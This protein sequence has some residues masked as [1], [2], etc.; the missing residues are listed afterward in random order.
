[1]FWIYLIKLS[2]VSHGG[3][4]N[5]PGKGLKWAATRI[6]TL[7][8]Q[9][10]EQQ[11]GDEDANRENLQY[12][13]HSLK[14]ILGH[15][16]NLWRQHFT[17]EIA[18][19]TLE[20]TQEE[21]NEAML[22][23]TKAGKLLGDK[24]Q[25]HP[26]TE[27]NRQLEITENLKKVNW[28]NKLIGTHQSS[29][30][31]SFDD[32]Y[33]QKVA[34]L[35]AFKNN[36]GNYLVGSSDAKFQVVKDGKVIYRAP[37]SL[38]RKDRLKG[39]VYSGI[40]DAYFLRLGDDLYRK[41]IDTEDPVQV[42]G[43]KFDTIDGEIDAFGRT[44]LRYSE[45]TKKL[46]LSQVQNTIISFDPATNVGEKCIE[47]GSD[48][49]PT[50]DFQPLGAGHRNLLELREN[51]ELALYSLK[52]N[53]N[54][55]KNTNSPLAVYNICKNNQYTAKSLTLCPEDRFA[56]VWLQE[57]AEQPT[58]SF[59]QIFEITD[60]STKLT[61]RT[62]LTDLEDYGTYL[63]SLFGYASDSHLVFAHLLTAKEAV[64]SDPDENN[65]LKGNYF[66]KNKVKKSYYLTLISFNPTS[67][68]VDVYQSEE[69]YYDHELGFAKSRL[70]NLG[71][72]E[73]THLTLNGNVQQLKLRI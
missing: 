32:V 4:S 70:V 67:H 60:D 43:V 8:R 62:E 46:Y 48:K 56:L 9:L 58:E 35:L 6:V 40:E 1:M 53:N 20:V 52:D 18:E 71:G 13:H 68:E 51:G 34:G 63:P 64:P 44:Y 54:Q 65:F 39:V 29:F 41:G 31:G 38:K 45:L 25:G 11:P 73:I 42:N 3:G 61:P 49:S 30:V 16:L 37:R 5:N 14:S 10:R 2:S 17:A 24:N 15:S 27:L 66:D 57:Q 22:S 7:E 72:F 55:A 21:W 50:A 33:E 28:S 69:T 36:E 26:A 47:K 59:F 23:L 12:L 19:K